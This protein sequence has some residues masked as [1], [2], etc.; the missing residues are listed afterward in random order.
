M[1]GGA[2]DTHEDEHETR[3]PETIASGV[4]GTDLRE[5]LNFPETRDFVRSCRTT[6][7]TMHVPNLSPVNPG[8]R[9][10]LGDL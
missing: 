9:K 6:L 8:E 4:L 5:S 3:V 2:K 7:T 1:G 10:T